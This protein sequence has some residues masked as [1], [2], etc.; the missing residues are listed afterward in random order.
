MA[1][2]Q[3][4]C[5]FYGILVLYS[6]GALPRMDLF[7]DGEGK[8]MKL[9]QLRYFQAVCRC[10][11]V[12]G[13]A[14]E[15]H[16]TQ[17]SVSASIRELE[18]EFGVI[19][20]HRVGRKLY[21]TREGEYL[22]GRANLLLEESDRLTITMRDLGENRKQLLLG[23]PP[24]IGATLFPPILA[25]FTA[26]YPEIRLEITELSSRENCQLVAEESL[27]VTFAL[28]AETDSL[29]FKTCPIHTTRLCYCVRRDHP[30]AGAKEVTVEEIG[31]DPIALFR[32]GFY[33]AE[34]IDEQFRAHGL[35]PH[36]VLRSTQLHTIRSLIEAGGVG[37]FLFEEMAR[38]SES[39]AAIPLAE[40]IPIEIGLVWKRNRYMHG[41]TT[42]FIDLVTKGTRALPPSPLPPL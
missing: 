11:S 35:T 14:G 36:V 41:S 19:L 24:M 2:G 18:E 28:L 21:L 39:I 23:V 38:G 37:S 5:G 17:P 3:F 34:R 6:K 8:A 31:G 33:H 7:L 22:L 27:D 1:P 30:L 13:A 29:V 12:T 42:R 25:R 4:S 40:S 26:R 15:L 32:E 20:F 10:G 16:I 9:N